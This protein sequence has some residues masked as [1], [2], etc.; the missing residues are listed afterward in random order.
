MAFNKHPLNTQPPFAPGG[1]SSSSHRPSFTPVQ[2]PPGEAAKCPVCLPPTGIPDL[3]PGVQGD[4]QHTGRCGLHSWEI[5]PTQSQASWSERK[6]W[7]QMCFW[8]ESSPVSYLK[9][10][11]A[12][13]TETCVCESRELTPLS[14]KQ[15]ISARTVPVWGAV[16]TLN[17]IWPTWISH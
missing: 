9:Q 8:D 1:L 12:S 13:F 10:N 2:V 7:S 14:T 17:Q 4:S 5:P 3:H 15:P 11:S 16:L 6:S